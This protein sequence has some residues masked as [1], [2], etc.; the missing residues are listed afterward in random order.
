VLEELRIEVLRQTNR[1]DPQMANYRAEN[2]QQETG[3]QAASIPMDGGS[4]MVTSYTSQ[5]DDAA[6]IGSMPVS[7]PGDISSWD[8]FFSMLSSGLGNLDGSA[9]TIQPGFDGEYRQPN[10]P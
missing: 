4:G 6:I 9:M 7:E 3:F 10:G 5:I 8:H 1:A 2:S